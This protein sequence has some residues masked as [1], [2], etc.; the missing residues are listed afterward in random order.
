MEHDRDISPWAEKLASEN[1]CT[2]RG[3]DAMEDRLYERGEP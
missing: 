1:V 3:E 2:T